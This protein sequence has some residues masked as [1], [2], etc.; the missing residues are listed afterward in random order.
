MH[1]NTVLS[2]LSVIGAMYMMAAGSAGKTQREVLDALAFTNDQNQP[3]MKNMPENRA[4]QNS[5]IIH[6]QFV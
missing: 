6:I 3:T 2:P 5:R 1:E 4:F